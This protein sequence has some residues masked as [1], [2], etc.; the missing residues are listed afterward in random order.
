MKKLL[1]ILLMLLM[2][3]ASLVSVSA[4]ET[5]LAY[6]ES[7]ALQDG[8]IPSDYE[9]SLFSTIDSETLDLIENM[10]IDAWTSL[11]NN[12][13]LQTIGITY[14][15][16]INEVIPFYSNVLNSHPE[17][18][19]VRGSIGYSTSVPYLAV[20]Y[21]YDTA[22]IPALIEKFSTAVDEVIETV[23]TASMSDIDIA[24]YLHDYLVLNAEYDVDTYQTQNTANRDAFNAYGVL[25]NKIGVCQSYTLAYNLLLNKLGFDTSCV[26]ST[27]LN[28]IWSMV[29]IGDSYYHVDVTHDDPITDRKGISK[30]TY[31]LC[32][33]AEL[34]A[35]TA[36]GTVWSSSYI[37][38][39]DAFSN[40]FWKTTRSTMAY[41]DGTYYLAV[42]NSEDYSY[43]LE[44]ATTENVAQTSVLRNIPQTYW[45]IEN[46]DGY[47]FNAAQMYV[48]VFANGGDIYYNNSLNVFRYCPGYETDETAFTYNSEYGFIRPIPHRSNETFTYIY[49]RYDVV[50]EEYVF[51]HS[52]EMTGELEG[53][54]YSENIT[55]P[56]DTEFG[57]TVHLCDTCGDQYTDTYVFPLKY[58]IGDVDGDGAVSSADPV[59]L[60]RH[61][62]KW[63]GYDELTY[64][65]NCDLNS[66]GELNSAD[67]VILSRHLAK[68]TGYLSLPLSD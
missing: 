8:Y 18:F 4:D 63:T 20:Y 5:E 2:I 56:S 53:H 44:S 19:Y 33:D 45:R 29:K 17:F 68:W 42:M 50:D 1:P 28:H 12:I 51:S 7:K 64:S 9:I 3:A 49:G 48:V 62:A 59:I 10:F 37:A 22:D 31:F 11:E 16:F 60:S 55:P 41:L 52:D 43:T 15:Q 47:I 67:A 65:F 34:L 25:V 21:N 61:L 57:Y 54:S 26:T 32:S 58:L 14:E 46:V 66:D 35:D 38:D 30:Y 36:H 24:L 39:S 6:Y 23:D 13:D 27:E 40:A